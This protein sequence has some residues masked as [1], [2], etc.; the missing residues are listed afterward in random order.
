MQSSL[1]RNSLYVNKR[2][3]FLL[4][5][6]LLLNLILG[7]SALWLIGNNAFLAVRRKTLVQ[8]QNGDTAIAEEHD[9]RYRE[10]EVLLAT[11]RGWV[12]LTYTKS[13]LLPDGE[14]DEGIE[15]DSQE[16]RVPTKTHLASFLLPPSYREEFL[17][18]YAAHFVPINF[19]KAG[20]QFS[21]VRI[22]DAYVLPGGNS[23]EGWT[24]EILSTVTDFSGT[25]ETGET[26][27][28]LAIKLV[29]TLPSTDP[30]QEDDPIELRRA[31]TKLREPGI[32]IASITPLKM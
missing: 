12:E 16:T 22:L 6:S 5:I 26:Y 19:F 10:E 2:F 1:G 25:Q 23:T 8:L 29:P 15:I 27:V 30:F 14:P 32:G 11:A 17:S 28:N 4:S 24:V 7:I 31:I 9:A 18:E 21:V 3:V 13:P 20:N